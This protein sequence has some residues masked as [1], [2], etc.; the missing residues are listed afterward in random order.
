M[1][2]HWHRLRVL[3]NLLRVIST[4]LKQKETSGSTRSGGNISRNSS[5]CEEGD[6]RDSKG[7]RRKRRLMGS[8]ETAF[9]SP[10]T[11]GEEED[12]KKEGEAAAIEGTGKNKEGLGQREGA[13]ESADNSKKA[14]SRKSTLS[15]RDTPTRWI[16]RTFLITVYPLCKLSRAASQ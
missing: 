14:A 5:L 11:V 12:G 3:C 10:R 1:G 8:P 9:L 6:E 2:T 16:Q 7:K 15:P 4:S 13:G